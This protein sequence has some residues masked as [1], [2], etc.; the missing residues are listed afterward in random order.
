MNRVRDAPTTI[1]VLLIAIVL[2]LLPGAVLS[3]VGYKSVNERARQ[4]EAGYHGALFLVRDKVELEVLW[5]EQ[6]LRSS[7]DKAATNLGSLSASRQ[8]LQLVAANNPWLRR[9]FL[10]SPDGDFITPSVSIGS[11]SPPGTFAPTPSMKTVL[12]AAEAAEFARKD[13]AG[14]LQLYLQALEKARS[15]E[16]R[17][18]LLARVGR[19]RFK[20]GS[21]HKGIQDYQRLLDLSNSVSTVGDVPILV[22]A[23]SQIADGYAAT[24]DERGHIGALLQLYQR[25]V[26][27]PWDSSA[28][29]YAYYLKQA[30]REIEAHVNPSDVDASVLDTHK[31]KALK[32]LETDRLENMEYLEWIRRTLIP[33]I[34]SRPNRSTIDPSIG[35]IS[36]KREA[37]CMSFGYLQIEKA[38]PESGKWMLG[39]EL[40]EE[41]IIESLLPRILENVDLGEDT[42]VG[43]LDGE[44]KVRFA[45]TTPVPSAFL[46][47]ENFVE[48]LP[49]WKVGLFHR[50]GRSISELIWREKAT[51]LAFLGGTLLVMILGIFLTVRAAAHEVA[52]SRLKSDFVSNVSHEFKTPLALIRMFGETLETGMVEDEAKRREFY[53]IIRAESERLTHLINKV[54]DFSR[55][56]AGVKQYD[57]READVV[58]AIRNTLDTYRFQTRDLG[59]TIDAQLPS[60][61]VMGRI[62]PDAV[63]EAL[64]NLLDNATK[65]SGE[66]R[67]IGVTVNTSESSITVSVEDH[68]V[69]IPKEDLP[70]IFGKFYRARTQQTQETP[71]SSL[72][73]ALVKHIVEAHGGR[74]G[75]ESELGRGSRFFFEIPIQG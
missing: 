28:E 55:I 14:A 69:G 45:Q 74:V 47:A 15:A 3:Y 41:R 31:L 44:G 12:S 33:E 53:R 71:G 20:L 34:L 60:H 48:I 56:D 46:A 23:L 37:T 16:E 17:A 5:L 22:V 18:I 2:I 8:M 26:Y 64:L 24:K 59:F 42:R 30:R 25:L 35:H 36:A 27:A 75:V 4:L 66:S 54:L 7:A 39:Y 6:G 10:A 19:C 13:T 29:A 50:D 49:S 51:Y 52:L 62:D 68:G 40:N 11:P 58:E 43:I 65:Y 9:P 32:E 73:L 57:F 67:H 38:A 61:P 70:N 1:K 63:S 72:G 21:Y